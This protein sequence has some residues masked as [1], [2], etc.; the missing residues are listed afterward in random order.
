M[1]KIQKAQQ[2]PLKSPLLHGTSKARCYM[3][4]LK[5]VAIQQYFCKI[6][7]NPNAI[8][9]PIL[10]NP[11]LFWHL[12]YKTQMLFWNLFYKAQML[13][14]HLI[15]QSPNAI[16][17][18]NFTNPNIILAPILQNSNA[19]LAPSFAK[20]QNYFLAKTYFHILKSLTHLKY[21]LLIS[22]KY[23]FYKIYG[24]YAYFFHNQ[25][26]IKTHV[27]HPWQNY[28]SCRDGKAQ[29]SSTTRSS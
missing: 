11:I 25:L 27:Y 24:N 26:T 8:L 13:F 7:Q 14:W 28:L 5:P 4:P 10:Q 20:A 12:V 19:I 16:L 23:L 21:K 15:F 6:L 9:A 2:N 18:P 22:Q 1:E 3:A 29:R 17:A